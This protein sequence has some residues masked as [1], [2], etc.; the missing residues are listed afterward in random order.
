MTHRIFLLLLLV[1]NTAW[2]HKPSDSYLSLSISGTTVRGQWDI[3]LRDLDYAIGLDGNG[4]GAITW[5]ELRQRQDAITAYALSHV[6]ISAGQVPCPTEA[7]DHLADYHTDG[8]YA[9]LRFSATCPKTPVDLAVEYRLFFDFDPQHKGLLR[10]EHAGKTK[11]AIFSA[12][13]KARTLDVT[14]SSA[15][16]EFLDYT[17][18]GIWHIWIGYDHILFLLS[19]L[20]PAVLYRKARDWLP[21]IEIRS[22]LLEVVKIVTAFTLAHSITLSLAALHLVELPA[23]VVE[24]AIAASVVLVALNNLYPL[25]HIQRWVVAL[26]FGLV[27]GLGFANV[28]TDLGLPGGALVW[29][30][31]GFNLGVEAG[32]LAIVGT[33][34]PLAYTIR[35]TLLYRRV[36]F[37][38]GSLA[39]ALVATFWFVER[40]LNLELLSP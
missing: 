37:G 10:L 6:S 28:L 22:A 17:R 24:S 12:E 2:A 30:L 5:G 21:V 19:L 1:T 18:E 39:I 35:R 9:V 32:Q 33:F 34:V 8:A 25:F 14:R 26:A 13:A 20:L 4:D 11:T 36:V 16:Q 38:L 15:F 7:Q 23:R 40:S 27:H 29:A 31:L 3:A